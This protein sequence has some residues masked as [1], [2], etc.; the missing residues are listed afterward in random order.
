MALG[1]PWLCGAARVN[2]Q[3]CR[4]GYGCY[5]VVELPPAG[6]LAPRTW[7]LLAGRSTLT[8]YAGHTP[9]TFSSHSSTREEGQRSLWIPGGTNVKFLNKS[10]IA[11]A[12]LVAVIAA[13]SVGCGTHA[14][15]SPVPCNLQQLSPNKTCSLYLSKSMTRQLNT[16]IINLTNVGMTISP[17]ACNVLVTLVP[18]WSSAYPQ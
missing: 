15:A 16:I 8:T 2:A 12:M 17:Q 3:R 1:G 4:F 7:G 11:M 9:T 14:F 18:G 13:S 6:R 5:G 10:S